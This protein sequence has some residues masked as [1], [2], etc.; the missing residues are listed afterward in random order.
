[1]VIPVGQRYQQTLYLLTKVDGKLVEKALQ[2]T[3][4]VPMTGSAE[5]Q[6]QVQPDP[7]KP[8]VVNGDFQAPVPPENT[9]DP[10]F[11]PGWY[12]GRQCQLIAKDPQDGGFVRFENDIPGRDSH[13]LQG[14]ALDGAVIPRIRLTGKVRTRDVQGGSRPDQVPT[15]AISFYDAQRRDLGTQW[16]TLFRGTRDWKSDQRVFRVPPQT[17]EVIVR[18]GLFGAT[19]QADFDDIAIEAL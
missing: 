16:L 3:L 5:T 6:R 9:Q 17:R 18:I 8:T 1:M 2:P 13:L 7:L 19:G 15:V 14:L 11:I 10:N 4:F 12:Y